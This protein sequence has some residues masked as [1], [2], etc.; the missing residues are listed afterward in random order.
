[1][2]LPSYPEGMQPEAEARR[3]ELR[4]PALKS[5]WHTRAPMPGYT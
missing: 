4:C 1:M 5:V 2:P 3:K